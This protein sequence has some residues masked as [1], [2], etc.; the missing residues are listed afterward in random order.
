[1]LLN[2]DMLYHKYQL[3]IKG[4]IH[5]GAHFGTEYNT[6]YKYG[7]GK[8]IFFEPLPHTFEVLKNNIGNKKDVILVNNALGNYNKKIIMNVERNNNGQS[9]SILE[10][11]LHLTQYPDIIFNEK[12]EVDMIKLADFRFDR[13]SYNFINIDVQGY[14]LEVFK[15][16]ESILNNIDYIMA[17]VNRDEVYENCAKIG[18]LD[19]FLSKYNFTR[20]ETVWAG[21]TW[22]DAFYVKNK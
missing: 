9:S 21:G 18:D 6:Y 20:V 13:N 16:A 22:G 1:M 12:I 19:N 3:T 14:E 8:C 15:G 7:I 5:I 10:P 17:E 11:V 2:F 4:V